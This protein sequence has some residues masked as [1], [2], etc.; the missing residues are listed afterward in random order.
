MARNSWLL[1]A[2][3]LCAAPA[4]PAHAQSRCQDAALL[5]LVSGVLTMDAACDLVAPQTKPEREKIVNA[6]VGEF[7]DCFAHIQGLSAEIRAEAAS[8]AQAI[9]RA[10]KPPGST[11]CTDFRGTVARLRK[12]SGR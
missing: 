8:A 7:R 10:T 6:L 1:V 3:L 2:A 4:A 9:R 11:T 12:L 5:D